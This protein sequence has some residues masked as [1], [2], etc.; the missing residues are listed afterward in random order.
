[1]EI[2]HPATM[3]RVAVEIQEA[4]GS[5][6]SDSSMKTVFMDVLWIG[7]DDDNDMTEK[8]MDKSNYFHQGEINSQIRVDPIE[9]TNEKWNEV[10]QWALGNNYTGLP[11]APD[12][13][14]SLALM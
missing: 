13:N 10:T 12:S 4:V 3:A 8:W 9:V 6:H 5:G 11:L 2:N 1:M 7:N 14:A